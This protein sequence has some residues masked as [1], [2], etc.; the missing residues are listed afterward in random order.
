MSDAI[1]EHP[2]A[3]NRGLILILAV[4]CGVTVANI[5]FPQA[6]SPLIAADLHVTVEAAASVVTAAQLGYAAGLFLLAPL[7]D[8][9]PHRP[10]I[11]TLLMLTAAALLV[12]GLAPTLPILV[13]ASAI[14]GVTTVIPQI[15]LP[16][17]AGLVDPERRGAV[18]GTLLSG[19]LG[20]IL[21]ARTFGGTLGERMGWRAPYLVAAGLM[22]LL[23]ALL[24][25]VI[26]KTVPTSRQRYFALVAASFALLRDEPELRRSCFNQATMFGGFTGAWTSLALFLNGPRYALGGQAVGLIALVGAASVLCTPIAGRWI[27]RK[28]S[29]PVNLVCFLG[30]IAAALTLLTGML[31]G[32]W[33]LIGLAGG[34][35]ILDAA[36]QC[37]QA[38][39]QARIFAL[40]PDARSRLNTAYMTCAF[41][42]GSAGS[43]LGARVYANL[44]WPGVCGLVAAAAALALIRHLGHSSTLSAT[45]R[46]PDSLGVESQAPRPREIVTARQ[47][48]CP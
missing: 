33:G 48:K 14:T 36:A 11:V 46:L 26:P 9:L 24:A 2:P 16:M 40:R 47:E 8:R 15:L 37:G 31:G 3:P 38:A 41:L 42:G 17:A 22:L 12:A 27:D 35:L 18:T 43:W 7:G 23:A 44:G 39:N 34:M 45:R 32:T 21:L 10:L 19:L 4:A 6:I 28:G 13:A 5:Y 1:Y 25:L 20:G 30:A 29:D